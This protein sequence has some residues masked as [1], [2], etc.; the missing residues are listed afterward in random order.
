[1]SPKTG[2]QS[3]P[4]VPMVSNTPPGVLNTTSVMLSPSLD[5]YKLLLDNA[6]CQLSLKLFDLHEWLNIGVWAG[7]SRVA[8]LVVSVFIVCTHPDWALRGWLLCMIIG[9]LLFTAVWLVCGPQFDNDSAALLCATCKTHF[10]VLSY[11]IN[12]HTLLSSPLEMWC[13]LIVI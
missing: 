9:V 12:I 4:L 3:S 8:V 5:I 7:V 11:L 2:I 13:S 1:M 10:Q 6:A